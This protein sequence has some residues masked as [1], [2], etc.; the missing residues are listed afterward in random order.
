MTKLHPELYESEMTAPFRSAS[1][2]TD[3]SRVSEELLSI[4]NTAYFQCRGNDVEKLR[5]AID[6]VSDRLKADSLREAAAK[7]R[8]YARMLRDHVNA[9]TP[10]AV[11]LD[12][13]AVQLDAD[14]DALSPA[15]ETK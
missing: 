14:A 1:P 8:S 10:S 11:V 7:A 9:K 6:A 3:P 5:A 4:A 12:E 13:L 15:P 2:M